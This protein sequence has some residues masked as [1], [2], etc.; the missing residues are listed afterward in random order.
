M[1]CSSPV[2]GHHV[3]G[4]LAGL[5]RELGRW[6]T[7]EEFAAAWEVEPSPALEIHLIQVQRTADLLLKALPERARR[8][9][10]A[11][12]ALDELGA[13]FKDAIGPDGTRGYASPPERRL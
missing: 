8:G 6:P 9:E 7:I 12:P 3:I 4:S 11:I 5:Y 10:K 2:E 1:D 13:R